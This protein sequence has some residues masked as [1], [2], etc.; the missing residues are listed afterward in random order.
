MGASVNVNVNVNTTRVDW[1]LKIG[2]KSYKKCFFLNSVAGPVVP[3]EE[4][5][6]MCCKVFF[7]SEAIGPD[8]VMKL[9]T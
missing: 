2:V 8:V 7:R 6:S 5:K 1:K 3:A 4:H 9:K